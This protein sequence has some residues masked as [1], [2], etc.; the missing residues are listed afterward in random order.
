MSKIIYKHNTVF[1]ACCTH[2]LAHT[3]T[4]MHAHTNMAHRK[5]VMGGVGI[6]QN[7][8]SVVVLF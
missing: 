1:L 3:D 6:R 7:V 8:K 4:I 2:T 5:N